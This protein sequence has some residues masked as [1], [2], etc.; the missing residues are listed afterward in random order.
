[1]HSQP[2]QVEVCC[3]DK[4]GTLTSDHLLLEEVVVGTEASSEA[5]KEA[6]R[7]AATRV[8]AAC[9]SLVQVGRLWEPLGPHA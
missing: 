9:H 3:F 1:M 5:E 6:R 8:M 2:L 7:P 4:T